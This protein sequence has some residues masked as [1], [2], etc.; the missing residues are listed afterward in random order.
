MPTARP[1]LPRRRERGRARTWLPLRA[2]VAGGVGK[3]RPSL[4]P[5]FRRANQRGRRAPCGAPR[6]GRGLR[7][8]KSELGGREAV[9]LGLRLRRRWR[10]GARDSDAARRRPPQGRREPRSPPQ[11]AAAAASPRPGRRAQRR[12]RG[13]RRRPERRAQLS[14]ERPVRRRPRVPRTLPAM[15]PVGAGGRAAAAAA[16]FAGRRPSLLPPAAPSPRGPVRGRAGGEG[17]G[18][19]GAPGRGA[20]RAGR[21]GRRRLSA[22]GRGRLRALPARPP[23]PRGRGDCRGEKQMHLGLVIPSVLSGARSEAG[24]QVSWVAQL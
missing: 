9:G 6:W 2:R 11:P 10:P 5:R 7:G 17:S 20:P 1:P 12:E 18:W 21:W 4:R 8:L 15:M 22:R 14:A 24:A 16:S 23:R 3:P 13:L 19:A